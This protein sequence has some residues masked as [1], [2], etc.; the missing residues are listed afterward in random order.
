MILNLNMI[1]WLLANLLIKFLFITKLQIETRDGCPS[2][3]RLLLLCLCIFLN[4]IKYL[5][6]SITSLDLILSSPSLATQ[7]SKEV[8]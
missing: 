8:Q 7:Q 2:T 1:I 6:I 4:K 3:L 5:N